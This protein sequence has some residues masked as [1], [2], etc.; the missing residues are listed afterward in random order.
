MAKD[1][2]SMGNKAQQKA[3]RAHQQA[4]QRAKELQNEI[5]F[6]SREYLII[7]Q[8]NFKTSWRRHN[9]FN[10]CQEAGKNGGPADVIVGCDPSPKT[11]WRRTGNY[12]LEMRPNR[13]LVESDNPNDPNRPK[14]PK[15]PSHANGPVDLNTPDDVDNDPQQPK[16][17]KPVALELTRV[18]FLIHKSIP[19]DRWRVV[20]YDDDNRD[21]VATLYMSTSIGE[22]AIHSVYNVNQPSKR[23]NVDLLLQ[24]T[25]TTGHDVV[26]GGFNLHD[27]TW[28]GPL[29]KPSLRTQAAISLQRGMRSANMHL[30]TPRGTVTCTA[31]SGDNHKTAA[32]IDLAFVSESLSDKVMSCG[33]FAQN[34]WE[35]SDHRPIRTLFDVK[36]HR[37]TSTRYQWRKASPGTLKA[38]ISKRTA[39]LIGREPQTTEET[40]SY[41]EALCT[42]ISEGVE[43]SVPSCLANPPPVRQPIDP[44]LRAMVQSDGLAPGLPTA[45]PNRKARR[46]QEF[47]LARALHKKERTPYRKYMQDMGEARNGLWSATRLAKQQC[48]DRIIQNMPPLV[49]G[50]DPD[51]RVFATENEKQQCL[52]RSLWPENGDFDKSPDV[53]FPYL[54][55]DQRAFVM[56]QSLT[57][58]EVDRIVR[59]LNL[60]KAAGED[61]IANEAIKM[62]REALVPFLATLFRACLKLSY[63]PSHFKIAITAMLRK[64]GKTT[65][66]VAKS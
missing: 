7:D 53:A 25:T 27:S 17:D 15:R 30:K 29:F 64:D 61:K 34:P 60:G 63:Y 46:A 42:A 11:A 18:F 50:K 20:Y 33:V 31:A 65:Y 22:I 40:Q 32:C 41:A 8:A 16:K 6:L 21:M 66:N 37:D 48:K 58:G 24:R 43:E 52:M 62:A 55:P 19:K 13:T 47:R 51:I 39:A 1:W 45:T 54:N 3:Q 4:Q 49:E 10:E 14:R 5:D 23:I 44:Y 56:D 9:S 2:S 36:P 26:M 59:E 38:S 35:P 12:W 28:A 57:N